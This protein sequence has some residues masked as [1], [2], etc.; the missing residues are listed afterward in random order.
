MATAPDVRNYSIPRGTVSFTPTNGSPTDLGNCTQFRYT[1]DITKLDHYSSMAG[2]RTK[3]KSVVTQLGA[4]ISMVLDEINQ[5]NM[6]LFVL[7]D[8]DTTGAI[9][10][11]TNTTLTGSLSFTGTNDVG[12]QVNFTGNVQFQPGGDFNMIVENEWQNIPL[13]AEVLASGG[14]Y[15]SWTIEDEPTA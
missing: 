1:A 3:D 15:G 11:L 12:S 14:T 2:I 4:T 6:A 9:G 13:N 5:F 7:G 10:G 8:T